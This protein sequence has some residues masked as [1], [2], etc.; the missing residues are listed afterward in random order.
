[1]IANGH[2]ADAKLWLDVI[3]TQSVYQ[4]IGGRDSLRERVLT[5]WLYGVAVHLGRSL[6]KIGKRFHQGPLGFI[7][8]IEHGV[9]V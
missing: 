8:L 2:R 1:L 9:P 3:F 5:Y 7:N 4:I 6:S